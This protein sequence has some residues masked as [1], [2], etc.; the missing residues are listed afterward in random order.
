MNKNKVGKLL[1]LNVILIIV[2]VFTFNTLFRLVSCN[3]DLQLNCLYRPL[4]SYSIR[5]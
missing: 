1:L 3:K 5:N 2:T 4:I